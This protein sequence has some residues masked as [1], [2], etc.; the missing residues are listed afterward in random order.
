MPL[1]TTSIKL[2]GPVFDAPQQISLGIREAVDR[3]LLDIAQFEGA[4]FVKKQLWGP[5]AS[6]YKKVSR[7]PSRRGELHGAKTRVLRNHIGAKMI[8]HVAQFD[9]GETMADDGRNLVY[10]SWVEGI[11][12]RNQSSTFKGYGMFKN[13]H[14]HIDNNP[15]MYEQYIGDAIIE[16]LE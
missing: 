1:E 2:N 6:Q 3:G 15:K 4:N 8:D 10:A 9:A 5:P 12:A 16:A 11:S 13:A 14:E 7:D